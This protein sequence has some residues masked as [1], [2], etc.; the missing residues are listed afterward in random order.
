MTEGGIAQWKVKEGDS[1]A[2][3]D[4]LIEI[5]TDK[6]T[7]DVEAQDDGIMAK[8]ISQDGAKGIAVGTPIAIIGE[9]GDDLSGADALAAEGG[10]S[11]SSSESAPK[12]EDASAPAPKEAKEPSSES[13]G[14][15]KSGASAT[16][17]LGTP[18]DVTNYGSNNAG[19][20]GQ[21]AP[22]LGGDRPKFF[23]SPLARKLALER[24]VPL[25]EIKG[26]G[27][28]GRIV[29]DDVEKYKGGSSSSAAAT[30]P[31]SG[32]TATPGKPAPAA[33]AEYEDIPVSNMRRTI[34]KRLTESKQ[35]LPHYYLT[36]EVNMDR[37]AKLRELFNKAGEGKTKLSVNDFIVKAAA[38]AL[39][40]VPEANSAWL[41]ETIRQY[42]K[43]DICV[44][45]A[46]PNGLITPIIKDVGAKGLASIS[47]ETKALASKARDGKL[48]PEEYQGGSFTISNLGMFGVDNFTA[49]INPP[50]SCILAI[51]KT[52]TKLELA[53]EDPK[54]F[55]AVQV[56]KATLSSDHR[57]VDGAVGAKW[58]K[59]F[60]DYLEQP[61][62]FML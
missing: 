36:V 35:Q 2:A 33:P 62:T 54:G 29:K 59:A 11:S 38:L 3:G 32:V 56:M 53:P 34:G 61:L 6:A 30:T 4:V 43:A 26:S 39:A 45:V 49:I 17:A 46:T 25:G 52:S 14:S 23:A 10:S 37:V 8:I 19:T 5:E 58:L 31:T 40:E 20:E 47:A 9:E 60:K 13:E 27:P 24:G 44:A 41:G 57:T 12:K 21:K 50:Q 18:A 48:K 1:F 7:I 15:G 22:E 42:K 28:E 51:G 16:P 55:K